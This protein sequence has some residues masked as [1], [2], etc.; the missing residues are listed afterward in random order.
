[1]KNAVFTLLG[2]CILVAMMAGC[3]SNRV[4]VIEPMNKSGTAKPIVTKR[5]IADK[6]FL[7]QFQVLGEN[8]NVTHGN[9]LEVQVQLR[10]VTKKTILLQYRVDWTDENMMIMDTTS[11]RW[12]QKKV[13]PGD[14]VFIGAIGPSP[15]AKDFYIKLQRHN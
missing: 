4:N 12:L 11:S 5:I 14:R 7:R 15:K 13:L 1:M 9:L 6:K 3:S 2:A 10:N 8:V